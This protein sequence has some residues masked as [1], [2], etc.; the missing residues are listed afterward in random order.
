MAIWAS[1][2]YEKGSPA[3]DNS[4]LNSEEKPH[5]F[6]PPWKLLVGSTGKAV[7]VTAF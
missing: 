5:D 1:A 3:P 2:V 6:N 7:T 4:W